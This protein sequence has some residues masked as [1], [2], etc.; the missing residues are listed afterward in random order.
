M[1]NSFNIDDS[2]A[3]KYLFRCVCFCRFLL[4]TMCRNNENKLLHLN[5]RVQNKCSLNVKEDEN[6]VPTGMRAYTFILPG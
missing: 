3:S 6:D 5:C 1:V 2:K 4:C